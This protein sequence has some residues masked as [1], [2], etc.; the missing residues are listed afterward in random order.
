VSAS[1]GHISVDDPD[2]GLSII[3]EYLAARI[4]AVRGPANLRDAARYALLGG[5]KRLR[6]LLAWQAAIAAGGT[7][8]EALPAAAAVEMVHAFSLVH[9]DLPAMDDDDLRRGRPTL[10]IHAGEAM[11][12]LTGDLLLTLA[13]DELQHGTERA[14]RPELALPL[15][16]ELSGA[17]SAMIAGQVL[18]TV[19]D[20]RMR[21]SRLARLRLTHAGK[22]A[23]LIRA[24]CR[25]G[26]MCGLAA[27]PA[28]ARPGAGT[29][30]TALTG[31]GEAVGLMFQA[32]DDLLDV[33]ATRQQTGKRTGKDAAAGKLTYPGLLGVRRAGRE[34]EQLCRLGVQA[35]APLGVRGATLERLCREMAVRG[36]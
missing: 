36:R 35:L 12:I 31:Y 4:D 3:E 29:V 23:A 25:M 17:T 16:R 34:V 13:F 10:H 19:G 8:T 20:A 6:P 32:V 7:G 27:R 18:D 24:S 1:A 28:K 11:A 22:T 15:I 9:D 5:G 30:L 14:G 33:Q 26:A 2:G 21:G